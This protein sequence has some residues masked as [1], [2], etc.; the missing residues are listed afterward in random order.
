MRNYLVVTYFEP[1]NL[2]C[3]YQS[4]GVFEFGAKNLFTFL[5]VKNWYLGLPWW[6]SGKESTC[7]C[8]RHRFD[9]WSRKIPHSS[10]QLKPV[11]HSYWTREPELLS[12]HAQLLKPTS[13]R[14]CALGQEKPPQWKARALQLESSLRLLQLEK[15]LWA[16]TKI[17]HSYKYIKL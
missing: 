14:A 6:L 1:V 7:Q 17:Q 12:P 9:P 2:W 8:R 16:V 10:E 4:F 15:S 11:H 3:I 5:C 13:P